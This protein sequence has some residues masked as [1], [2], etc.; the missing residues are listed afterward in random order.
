MF[1]FALEKAGCGPEDA[2]MVGDQE[3]T[4]IVGA[5]RMGITSIIVKT[6][7]YSREESKT[8]ADAIVETV[9]DIAESI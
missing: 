9:D 4:D 3:E 2:V 6:G 5:K 7:V 8:A 1:E